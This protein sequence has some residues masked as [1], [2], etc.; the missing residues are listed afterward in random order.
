MMHKVIKS[1]LATIKL[2]WKAGDIMEG[3][4]HKTNTPLQYNGKLAMFVHQLQGSARSIK[5]TLHYH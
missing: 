5:I 1:V 4:F 2:I 3:C